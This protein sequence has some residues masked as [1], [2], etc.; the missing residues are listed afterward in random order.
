MIRCIDRLE[1]HQK[2]QII[3]DGTELTNDLKKIDEV[4]RRGASPCVP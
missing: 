2:G 3:V 1:E 4:R